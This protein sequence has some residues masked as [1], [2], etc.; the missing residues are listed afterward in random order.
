MAKKIEMGKE[1]QK[2]YNELVKLAKTA[3]QRLL[4]IERLT[5]LQGSFA[6]KQL[7]DYLD[8]STLQ[9]ITPAS[10]IRISK[11]YNLMQLK[12]IKKATEQFLES[13]ISSVKGIKKLTKTYSEKAGKPISYEQADVLYQSGRNYSWI[14]G[15]NGLTESEFWGTWVPLAKSGEVDK[16]TWIEKLADRI[17]VE[18]DDYYREKLIDIYY[19]VIG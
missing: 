12:A 16:E 7:Y 13:D 10:R 3:N 2:L 4:R 5:G 9:A 19:Y 1:E 17:D 6:S 8:S 14:I 11:T 15:M 18:L